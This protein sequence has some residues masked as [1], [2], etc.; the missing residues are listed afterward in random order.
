LIICIST[1]PAIDRQL[2]LERLTVGGVNRASSV[3]PLPGGKAAHVA[4]AALAFAE[5]VIWVGFLGGAAGSACEIGLQALGIP[6]AV[7]CTAAETRSNL[8]IIESDGRVTEVLEPGGRVTDQEVER[9]LSRCHDVFSEYRGAAQVALSGSLAP[10]APADFYAQV[11]R[12]ARAQSC[13]VL[14]DTSGEALGVALKESPDFV[15]PN[16]DEAEALAGVSV[17][18]PHSAAEAARHFFDAGAR[19]VAISLG[20]DGMF[21]QESADSTPFIARTPRVEARS[22]VGCGDA[23]VAGFAVAHRRRLAGA[24]IV[25]FAAACGTANCLAQ[26]P[27]MIDAREVERIAASSSVEPVEAG[28]VS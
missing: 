17:F 23:S 8:E 21:W 10:G 11:I 3:R 18:D 28:L 16:R 24:E 20:V 26:M 19:G 22:A 4:M 14:L 12:L 5:P 25:R 1:N 7:I 2:R 13:R 6:I 27:G 15:K 9:M